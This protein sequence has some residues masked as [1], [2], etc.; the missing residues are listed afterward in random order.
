MNNYP[1]G[2]EHDPNA[3]WNQLDPPEWEGE[4]D[5]EYSKDDKMNFDVILTDNAGGT[6]SFDSYDLCSDMTEEEYDT[7]EKEMKSEGDN[8]EF[9][10]KFTKLVEDYYE[11]YEPEFDNWPNPEEERADELYDRLRDEG[12]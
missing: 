10:K 12:F 9:D 11:K 7:F 1:P 3:P 5:V 6:C 2:A 4:Y 8:P